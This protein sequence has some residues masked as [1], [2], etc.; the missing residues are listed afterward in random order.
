MKTQ[1]CPSLMWNKWSKKKSPYYQY[2]DLIIWLFCVS[3]IFLCFTILFFQ[4]YSSL[5]LGFWKMKYY[6]VQRS[7]FFSRLICL[8]QKS[9]LQ[10]FK[11]LYIYYVITL[12]GV[13]LS[14][15][16]HWWQFVRGVNHQKYD[17]MTV[18]NANK[19]MKKIW[20]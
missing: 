19:S 11:G 2:V 3:D 9:V 12:G 16:D 17:N 13:L 1:S 10:A 15:Y 6:Q 7:L 8:K 5:E 20:V 14:K 4:E 18:Q